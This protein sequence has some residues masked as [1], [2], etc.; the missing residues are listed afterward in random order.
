MSNG[1]NRPSNSSCPQL[2]KNQHNNMAVILQE[3]L[4]EVAHR[5]SLEVPSHYQ[6]KSDIIHDDSDPSNFIHVLH[7]TS[8]IMKVYFTNT[9][10]ESASFKIKY[11]QPYD[12]FLDIRTGFSSLCLCTYS[13]MGH[14]RLKFSYV[15]ITLYAKSTNTRFKIVKGGAKDDFVLHVTISNASIPPTLFSLSKQL[16]RKYST[17]NSCESDFRQLKSELPVNIAEEVCQEFTEL[18]TWFFLEK[19]K[20]QPPFYCSCTMFWYEPGKF[21]TQLCKNFTHRQIKKFHKRTYS[22][23]GN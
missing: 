16:V 17:L 21:Y 5:W 2:C 22:W 14:K 9:S 19:M 8:N 10:N 6:C 20:I 23:A 15:G 13:V 11:S 3:K 4:D 18:R 1:A 7:I 12:D